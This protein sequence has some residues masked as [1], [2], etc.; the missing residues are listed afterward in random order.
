L[1]GTALVPSAILAHYAA[2]L[3]A[4]GWTA[5]SPAISE[6][7][8]AQFFEAKDGSGGV[9]EGLLTAIDNGTMKSASLAMHVRAKP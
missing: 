6:R 2:Q 1:P 4:A 9:W 7:V 8:A 3:I 5:A